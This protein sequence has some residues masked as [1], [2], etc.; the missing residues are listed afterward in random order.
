MDYLSETAGG[1]KGMSIRS[2]RQFDDVI[3]ALSGLCDDPGQ[4]S[5]VRPPS[6]V[7]T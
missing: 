7:E 1:W 6:R 5:T 3:G 2:G 4:L